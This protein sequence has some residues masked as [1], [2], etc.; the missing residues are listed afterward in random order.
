MSEFECPH[1]KSIN[2]SDSKYCRNCGKPLTLIDTHKPNNEQ[3]QSMDDLFCLINGIFRSSFLGGR[4]G[5]KSKEQLNQI[6]SEKVVKSQYVNRFF[7]IGDN[8]NIFLGQTT[9]S[10]LKLHNSIKK[11]PGFSGFA[12]LKSGNSVHSGEFYNSDIV[13]EIDVPSNNFPPRWASCGISE[14]F[15]Y[16]DVQQWTSQNGFVSSV[17]YQPTV[18][19]KVFKTNTFKATIYAVAPDLSFALEFKFYDADNRHKDVNKSIYMPNTLVSISAL[20]YGSLDFKLD[21]ID[22]AEA[23][24]F[25]KDLISKVKIIPY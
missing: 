17:K 7:P 11:D 20:T 15:S 14:V 16:Y 21:I 3:D 9:I 12:F 4:Y 24:G 2:D 8:S 10:E 6:L 22:K 5:E 1:C 23:M 13:C 25:D 18:E 19:R